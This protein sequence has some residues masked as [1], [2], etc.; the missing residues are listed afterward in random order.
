[1][2]RLK[3]GHARV[4]TLPD[5]HHPTLLARTSP[6]HPL[7]TAHATSWTMSYLFLLS[8]FDPSPPQTRLVIHKPNAFYPRLAGCWR[9]Q[10]LQATC[11][12]GLGR[13]PSEC[14]IPGK[15]SQRKAGTIRLGCYLLL[16]AIIS[17]L[18]AWTAPLS[19]TMGISGAAPFIPQTWL[20]ETTSLRDSGLTQPRGHQCLQQPLNLFSSYP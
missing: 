17:L 2:A 20:P 16:A 1:V 11:I 3:V 10:R 4:P 19:C 7:T 14:S 5:P 9:Q 6:R 18:L 8:A 12:R 15:H 13:G